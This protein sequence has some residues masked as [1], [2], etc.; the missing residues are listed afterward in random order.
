[1]KINIVYHFVIDHYLQISFEN[2]RMTVFH[3]QVSNLMKTI[4]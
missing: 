4:I 1:M 3:N 2:G